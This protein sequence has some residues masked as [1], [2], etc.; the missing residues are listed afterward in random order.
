VTKLAEKQSPG[1]KHLASGAVIVAGIA[2]LNAVVCDKG[3]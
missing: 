3:H 1:T 2:E